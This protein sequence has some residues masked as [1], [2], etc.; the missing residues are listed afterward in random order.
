MGGRDLPTRFY[1]HICGG[2]VSRAD[3]SWV[4]PT[5]PTT[6]GG[7]LHL[8]IRSQRD[9]TLIDYILTD[10]DVRTTRSRLLGKMTF[11]TGGPV[12]VVKNVDVE[13]TPFDFDLL[14]TLTGSTFPYD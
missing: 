5:L 7:K 6:G 9:P 14:R 3:V 11:E 12:L 8:E 2:E 1:L 10:M 13:G 4:D